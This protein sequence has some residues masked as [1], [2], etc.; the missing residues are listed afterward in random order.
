MCNLILV[1]VLF[2]NIFA[3]ENVIKIV[4]FRLFFRNVY[5]SL[6][7]IWGSA[8]LPHSLDFLRDNSCQFFGSVVVTFVV[9]AFWGLFLRNLRRTTYDL[10]C[11]LRLANYGFK[12]C[13]LL[14]VLSFSPTWTFAFVLPIL[15]CFSPATDCP[16]FPSAGVALQWPVGQVECTCSCTCLLPFCGWMFSVSGAIYSYARLHRAATS[17][18]TWAMYL[19]DFRDLICLPF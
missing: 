6:Q 13:W 4:I 5:I 3:C 11:S 19:I 2:I 16:V 14:V 15:L 8:F 10:Q 18:A 9:A 12:S 1:G 7:G 17:F